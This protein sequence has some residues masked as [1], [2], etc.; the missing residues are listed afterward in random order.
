MRLVLSANSRMRKNVP[1]ENVITQSVVDSFACFPLV[2]VG[3]G[4]VSAFNSVE[5][6]ANLRS[7]VRRFRG[8]D[9]RAGGGGSCDLQ[10]TSRSLTPPPP[11]QRLTPPQNGTPHLPYNVYLLYMMSSYCAL[12]MYS[13]STCTTTIFELYTVTSHWAALTNCFFLSVSSLVISF[14]PAVNS[15]S[16]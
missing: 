8:A 4:G 10:Q 12:Y 11:S 13:E 3:S 7:D 1:G 5:T 16:L 14:L 15:S 9:G 2:I 6:V